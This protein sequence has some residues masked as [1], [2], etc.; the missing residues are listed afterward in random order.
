MAKA[1]L[2]GFILLILYVHTGVQVAG[3]YISE[4]EVIKWLNNN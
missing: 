3:V 4:Q 2:N 1:D